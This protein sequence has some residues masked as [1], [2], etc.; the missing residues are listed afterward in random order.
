MSA[1]GLAKGQEFNLTEKD[2]TLRNVKIGVG[3]DAPPKH[4]GYDVDIDAVAFLLNRDN[5]V[6]MDSDFVFYNNMTTESGSITH[7]GDNETGEGDG[8]DEII[9]IKVDQLPFDVEK[10][11]FAVTLHNAEERGETFSIVKNA[12]I[13]IVNE[14]TNTELARFDL[15]EDASNENGIIFGELSREGMGWKFKALGQGTDGGLFRIAKDYGVNVSP[16]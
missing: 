11:A 8:D 13:R 2:P 6:R 12:F 14:D 9:H 5:R 3:W 7:G 15:S 16:V 10:I 4:E 1:D